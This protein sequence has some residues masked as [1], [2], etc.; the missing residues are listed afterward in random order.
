MTS[1]KQNRPADYDA[2]VEAL[3]IAGFRGEVTVA[4][5]DRVV[6]AT[7]N[8]IYQLLPD[9]VAFPIDEQDL[10]RIARLIDEPRFHGIV[11][12]P[13]GGG[14]GTNGQSLGNGLVVDCSRHMTKILEI[15]AEEGWVRVQPGVIKDQ[16]NAALKPLGLFFAPELSTSSRATLGGMISTDA[17]GQGSC[18]YGK[19][20]NH[21]LNLRAVLVG[22]DVL[23]TRRAPLDETA[24]GRSAQIL[25]CLDDI[26]SRQAELIE[27][28]FPK[29]NRSLTGY[30]LAH[31]RDGET[32]DPAA[33]LCG[34]EGTLALIAQARLRVLPIPKAASL[35]LIFYPDFQSA[36]RDA[37]EMAVLGAT[38]VETIDSRVLGLAREEPT[39]SAVAHLFPQAG[40]QGVN[41]VEFT[42]D[43]PMALDARVAMLLSQL[44]ALPA[45][46]AM[47]VARHR[48]VEL[49]W[50]LRKA[51]VGLL[52][53]A[54]GEKRPIPFVEDCAVPPENLEAFITGFR[55][56]LDREGLDYG[57]F[58][59]VDAGVLH[60]RPAIDLTD[61]SQEP[62]IRR[63]TEAVVALA[64]QHGGLLWGEHGKGV[65]SEFVP[66]VFGPLYPSLQRIK[67]AFDPRN[68]MNPG[69]IATPD[70]SPLWKIDAVNLRGQNDRQVEADVRKTYASAFGCNGNGACFNRTLDDVMCPS[71]KVTGDRR[72]SPKGRAGLVREWLRQGGADGRADPQFETEVKQAIDG[73]LSCGACTSQ[74]P[75][76]VDVPSL[77]ALFLDSYF[78]HHRRSLRDVALA[79]LEGL[80][81]LASRFRWAFNLMTDGP[82]TA[83][84]SAIGLTALP[85]MPMQN[86]DLPW[87]KPSDI[88]SLDPKRDV[89]LVPDAFTQFFEPQIV[90]DLEA[91]LASL[92]QRLWLAPY[93]PSGKAR[94]VLGR[95]SGFSTQAQRQ[96]ESL[97]AIAATGVPLVGLEPPVTLSY[98]SDYPADMP[99]VALPQQILAPLIA[100]LPARTSGMTVRLLPHCS[101]RVLGATATAGWR[102]IFERLGITLETPATGCCGM[103]GIWGH[104]TANRE[105]SKAIFAQSWQAAVSPGPDAI[106]ATGFSCRCQ[107]AD[108]TGTNL[109]HPVSLLRQLLEDRP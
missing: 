55:A 109:Q 98:R 79:H 21:V 101:E 15:N 40:A 100:A 27:T 103:A 37:R 104:E 22:G 29:L 60:V 71:Y 9:A 81:P 7:D 39:F 82:G 10:V 83:L 97:K 13:R 11:L 67:A 95:L 94:K 80:L 73:C 62:L 52:G 63:I 87:L 77:R 84:M 31:I 19:T 107:T 105:K 33:V 108:M 51:A 23:E 6:L 48:E 85:K 65:R 26:S 16:L 57:M 54:A 35:I 96:I 99:S 68:Q 24:T 90:A 36:L 47:T 93:R 49:V 46:L 43:D 1:T 38:S 61:S 59:H 30:D 91:V 66:E 45:R 88:P 92:N 20:S 18:V 106:L 75:V 44:A 12:R 74:C 78:R 70:D 8:S 25:A 89:V 42:D 34:S 17:C 64:R 69:K 76:R 28:R 53:R 32:I 3:K 4:S 58:G 86:R 56:I 5:S 41:I 2:F 14:T 72:H 102:T 50:G